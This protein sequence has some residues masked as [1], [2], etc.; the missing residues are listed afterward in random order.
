MLFFTI[1]IVEAQG[2]FSCVN[3]TDCGSPEGVVKCNN[4][5]I[6]GFC[7]CLL[8]QCYTLNDTCRVLD[9]YSISDDLECRNGRKSRLTALLLSIFLIN[10]GAANFYIER[11][12]LAAIQL[13]LG[14][15]LCCVQVS[16]GSYVR[17]DS[18]LS[19]YILHHHMCVMKH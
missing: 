9:C 16:G 4:T 1:L 11:Y 18:V 8:P 14:L 10:F 3:D 7:M 12:E 2:G 5:G 15:L 19:C 13:V 6:M 17:N